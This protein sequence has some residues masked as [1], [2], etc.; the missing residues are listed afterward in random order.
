MSAPIESRLFQIFSAGTQTSMSGVT[1]T[2]TP[3]DLRAMTYRYEAKKA[4]SCRA[5]LCLGHPSSNLPAY[6]EVT[7]L[8]EENGKLF[9]H[10]LISP[11]LL[12]AVKN[13]RYKKIS[14]AFYPPGS[15]ASPT[16]D[17]WSLRH[18]GFLGACPPA[19][20]GMAPLNFSSPSDAGVCC[21]AGEGAQFSEARRP[22]DGTG[23]AIAALVESYMEQCPSLTYLRALRLATVRR[24]PN[25]YRTLQAIFD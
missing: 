24:E 7:D 17:G 12:A 5:P 16:P 4:Q 25:I 23:A 21:F 15:P 3:A 13:G 10:A 18:V 2:F 22:L 8:I 19:V 6:G 14:A 1:L 11:A 20:R 9:A